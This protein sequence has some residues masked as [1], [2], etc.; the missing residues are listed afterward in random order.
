VQQPYDPILAG[1]MVEAALDAMVCVDAGGRIVLVNAQTER[2]FGYTRDDLV[3]QP[4]ETLVPDAVKARHSGLR[5]G[6]AGDS[7]P[8]GVGLELSGRRRDGTTFS[9]E[10]SLS[11][12]GADRDRLVL[13]AIRDVTVQREA[14]MAQ[15]RLASI[16]ESSEDAIIGK[17]LDGII[18]SWNAGA[19]A[20]YGYT[21]AEIT[22]HSIADL[23]PPDRLG[24]LSEILARL[25]AG[26]RIDHYQTRRLRKDGTV[27]DVSVSV[28]PLRDAAGQ[29]TGFATVASDIT[30]QVRAA[31]EVR[32]YRE[33]AGRSQRLETVGQ[34]AAGV[35]HDFNNMLGAIAGFASLI[36]D[37]EDPGDASDDA[38]QILAAVDRASRLTRLLLLVGRRAITRPQHADLNAVITGARELLHASLGPTITL[39]VNLATDPPAIWADPG[40]LEQAIL[41]LA[42]NARDAMP[43][44]GTLTVT[45]GGARLEGERPGHYAELTVTD[46]GAG[47]TPEVAAR[48]FEPFYTTKG[49]GAGTGLGLSTVDDIIAQTGGTI[50]VTSQPGAGTSFRILIPATAA[51]PAQTSARPPA[52]QPAQVQAAGP[53]AAGNILITDDE[54]AV[55]RTTARMLQRNG[56]TPL[57]AATGSQALEILAANDVEI[58]LTDFLMP[59]MTGTELAERARQI[60][61]GLP[62]L[63]MSG[64][65]PPGDQARQ[66]TFIHKP[67]T[68]EQLLTKIRALL[69]P[70][71]PPASLGMFNMVKP[72][73]NEQAAA[74][75][76]ETNAEGGEVLERSEVTD[77][78]S[79]R[80]GREVL[81][82]EDR[83]RAQRQRL[84]SLGQLAGGVAHD[85][86]NLLAVILNYVSFVSEDVAAA[87]AAAVA[88]PDLASHL[89]AASADLDEVKKAGER[90]AG[91]THQLLV[92]ARREV[93]RP[94]VLDLDTVITAVEEMLRRTLGEH[95][96]LVTSLAG[97]LWPVLAD[98]GQ[99][100]QVLVNLALNARDAMPAGGTLT[101][102]TSNITVDDDTI[103][104]GSQARKG[105]N[106][107]L[108]VGDTGTG[109]PA[110]VGQHVFEPFF[111]TKPDG[112]G[113]GL[114]LATVYGILT[115][116]DGNIRIYSEPGAGTTFTITLPVTAEAAVLIAEPVPYQRT[117]KGET[118]L[119]VEDEDALREVTRRIF[120][121]NGYQVITAA[122]GPQALRVAA[123]HPGEIHLLV[124]DVVMPHMLGKEVAER[125]RLIRPEI[126]VVFMSGYARG[127][128]TSEGRLDPGVALVEKPFS[129][130]DLLAV[131]GQA[132]NGHFQGFTTIQGTPP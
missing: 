102:D 89:E 127:V 14:T 24:E 79:R 40:Q 125:M 87:A 66:A 41:N 31:D 20:M 126:E 54:P 12:I 6:Y 34:L 72:T 78:A 74:R 13:A 69:Q 110:D 4:V 83:L 108:R 50:T 19:Q 81:E 47:M 84:E 46:T 25:A 114:G 107:R 119:V 118:V 98:P 59:G 10:I 88:G 101:I 122:D 103:A 17:T 23:L 100:E 53:P 97:D 76:P 132:L 11:A 80:E 8:M 61:P 116:A 30:D 48:A 68:P 63:H 9:A 43:D 56:Y 21:A 82:R 113:T 111:T 64:Y 105:R 75:R 128:L 51:V 1:L 131:A 15:A 38:Q 93:I 32:A 96:E 129:E 112:R 117:P 5:D 3:G 70:Q 16:I 123:G 95:I 36:R 7:R 55:L 73:G 42:I 86:N 37:G 45:T 60:R 90:A 28:S 49:L 109:I 52:P 115:Q 67:F 71:A 85:F 121:R 29:V 77:N 94:Q 35:A 27:I 26:E 39:A 65:T 22:G 58:L 92:F 57:E 62:V 91:L 44:G 104:G 106:V 99:L 130:A 124:I 2:L 33:Q 120:T 18:T